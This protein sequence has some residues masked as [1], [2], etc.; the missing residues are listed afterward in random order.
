MKPIALDA[1]G[2]D[3]APA[4]TVEG[5]L[6]AARQGVPLLLVGE[7]E[8]LRA[9]LRRCQG[10]LPIQPASGVLRME[11]EISALRHRKEASIMVAME[12][13]RREEVAGVVSMGH[14]GATLAAALLVLGRFPGLERPTL[15]LELP[16]RQ[17]HTLLVD[18]GAN[19]DC[20]P[21]WLFQ[22]ALLAAHYAELAGLHQPKVGLLSVGE[23][24]HKGNALV[25]QAHAL[26]EQAPLNFY[27]NVEGRDLFSGAVDIVVTDG[28]TGNALLKMAEGEAR[29][30]LEL[31]RDELSTS[32][33]GRLGGLLIR[34]PLRALRSRLDPAEYGAMPLL[35]VQGLVLVGHGAADAHAVERA[36]DKAWRLSQSGLIPSLRQRWEA[37]SEGQGG[38]GRGV[39]RG[40]SSQRGEG[41]RGSGPGPAG[42][43]EEASQKDS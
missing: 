27:G 40:R 42:S 34:T 8:Q 6:R 35:G 11:E 3:R 13:L 22:F 1:M 38:R 15:L 31:I 41:Q 43:G 4:V 39:G 9:E 37:L 25:R 12:F 24:A 17:G 23:E 28:F 10:D 19:L 21:Q 20:T 30:I 36:L 32:L 33:R 7:P 5:A 2:G 14:T 18:G 29:A 26:L 16:R